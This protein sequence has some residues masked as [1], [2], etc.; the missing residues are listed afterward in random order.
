[1]VGFIGDMFMIGGFRETVTSQRY[2]PVFDN[3]PKDRFQC[4][5]CW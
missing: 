1:M 4:N 2:G 3:S 5:C